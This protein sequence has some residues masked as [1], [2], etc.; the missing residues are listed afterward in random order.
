[1]VAEIMTVGI[2]DGNHCIVYKKS[3]PNYMG[4]PI[5]DKIMKV[6]TIWHDYSM[7]QYIG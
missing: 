2:V 1:M 6:A 4:S 3:E 7:R 5:K